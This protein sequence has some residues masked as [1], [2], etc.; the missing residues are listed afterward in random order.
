MDH[1]PRDT[2]GKELALDYLRQR[3][4]SPPAIEFLGPMRYL[5]V[6]TL[7]AL[8][9]PW[10]WKDPRTTVTLPFWLALFPNARVIHLVRNGIDVAESL[11]QR[12]MQGQTLAKARWK[13]YRGLFRFLDKKGWFGTSPRLVRRIEGV[14]LWE[15]Y[16]SWADRHTTDLQERLQ[17]VRFE[18]L[19][20]HPE[21]TL[22]S[23]LRFCDLPTDEKKI[24]QTLEIL[25]SEGE[26]GVVVNKNRS[27]SD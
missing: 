24:G 18:D 10:G 9:E 25:L 12:Q 26:I 13:Q 5:R 4:G 14:R 22:P 19:V 16:L 20:A 8:D 21:E 23:I 11:Y 2:A 3:L 17:V 6:R 15:E 27:V 7:Q 1:L